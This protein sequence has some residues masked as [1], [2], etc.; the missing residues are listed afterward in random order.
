[1]TVKEL[2]EKLQQYPEDTKVVRF[3]HY[4]EGFVEVKEI[5]KH[6][7]NPTENMWWCDEEGGVLM[8]RV[9]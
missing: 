4:P 3:N 5:E 6:K 9:V 7:F 8:I 1:M 2:I